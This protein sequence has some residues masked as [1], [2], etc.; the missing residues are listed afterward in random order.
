M[1]APRFVYAFLALVALA[2][3]SSQPPA[4]P[5]I[6]AHAVV[7]V[8]AKQLTPEFW[9]ARQSQATKIV[10][11]PTAIAAQNARLQ[12]LDPTVHDLAAMPPTLAANDVREWLKISARPDEDMF[13]GTGRKLE[14]AVFDDL[15]N[16]V[17]LDA[18]P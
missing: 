8:E 17:A 7:G 5:S 10:L 11:D 16:N 9:I 15:L 14:S 6:P 12:K 13:D 18:V 1:Q 4:S 3:C 2:S